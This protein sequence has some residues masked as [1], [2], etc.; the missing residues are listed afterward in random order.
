[1]YDGT[2][3]ASTRDVIVVT[4]NYRLGAFGFL[5]TGAL[6]GA[7]W[8]GRQ[9]TEPARRAQRSSAATTASW[10]SVWP[11]RWGTAR[12][13]HRGPAA[14]RLRL[15]APVGPRQHR[16]LRRRPRPGH[17]LGRV[18]GRHVRGASHGQ[19]AQVPAAAGCEQTRA[20]R[21]AEST[22]ASVCAVACTCVSQQGPV[23][24]CY[25]G[26]QPRG[27]ALQQEQTRSVRL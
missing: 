18:C 13:G 16:R 24:A 1:M 5:V 20:E 14:L 25:H 12:R 4:I 22:R 9:L 7:R 11:W 19:P 21:T 26:K 6:G 27:P 8:P 2:Y 17:H 10:T 23:C 3:I 15:R